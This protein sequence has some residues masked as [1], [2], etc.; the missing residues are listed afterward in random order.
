MFSNFQFVFLA[1]PAIESG[2]CGLSVCLTVL[3]STKFW[4]MSRKKRNKLQHTINGNTQPSQ[5]FSQSRAGVIPQPQ[6]SVLSQAD[7]MPQPQSSPQSPAGVIPHPQ[8]SVL[9]QVDVMPHTQS[10]VPSQAGVIPLPQSSPKSQSS[11]SQSS[12]LQD[13]PFSPQ[14]THM[15]LMMEK[16]RLMTPAQRTS[17][18]TD[19]S[20]SPTKRYAARAVMSE[21]NPPQ[22]SRPRLSAARNL[23]KSPNQS[24]TSTS[25]NSSR[26]SSTRSRKS[27]VP[28]SNVQKPQRKLQKRTHAPSRRVRPS[29]PPETPVDMEAIRKFISDMKSE[30]N[31]ES[32]ATVPEIRI[33]AKKLTKS[34]ETAL[35][36]S[37]GEAHEYLIH[38]PNKQ[39]PI[40][41]QTKAKNQPNQNI[42]TKKC[43]KKNCLQ[44]FDKSQLEELCSLYWSITGPDSKSRKHLFLRNFF[45][46]RTEVGERFTS[47]SKKLKTPRSRKQRNYTNH[48][49]LFSSLT[50]QHED[51]CLT[52][53]KWTFNRHQDIWSQV[54]DSVISESK[55]GRS[56]RKP[57]LGGALIEMIDTFIQTL[58]VHRLHY[59][60]N[61]S[62]LYIS[63]QD[64]REPI[65]VYNAFTQRLDENNI[66]VVFCDRTFRDRFRKFNI[67]FVR[68]Y[69]DSCQE[70]MKFK[71][72]N[73]TNTQEFFLHTFEHTLGYAKYDH[74][75]ADV[76][77]DQLMVSWDMS[78]VRECP[79]L[80]GGCEYLMFNCI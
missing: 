75:K 9:S 36:V 73:R 58:P 7:V 6:S 33:P 32:L 31:S 38:L 10:S 80:I 43:C 66:A 69:T 53:L 5:S 79:E 64:L 3:K 1:M 12:S 62:R 57:I 22:R 47:G 16:I 55:K 28:L 45:K 4:S 2:D 35:K 72:T 20:V 56:G 50:Q 23:F 59:R 11:F 60:D 8:S 17:L 40:K 15:R 68:G 44:K 63:R 27:W 24:Q 18:S 25:S 14:V 34:Q 74:M 51:V 29:P 52:L 71:A 61:V 65:D 41:R 37:A 54:A 13:A 49:W 77:V 67:G 26:K 70:C 48:W 76:P 39:A 19:Q 42:Y 21:L 78:R 46:N 30:S